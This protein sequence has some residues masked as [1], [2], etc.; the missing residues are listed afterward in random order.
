[1]AEAAKAEKASQEKAKQWESQVEN[2][3]FQVEQSNDLSDELQNLN[4]HLKQG[5]KATAV[6]IGKVVKAKKA[7]KESDNDK[8][9]IDKNAES[10][11]HF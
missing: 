11:I 9:H 7:I 5:T 4:D 2:F 6:Y 1:V 8:A 10:H 3:K